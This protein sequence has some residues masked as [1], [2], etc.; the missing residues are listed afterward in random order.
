ML[1]KVHGSNTRLFR[2]SFSEPQ[3]TVRPPYEI[4]TPSSWLDVALDGYTFAEDYQTETKFIEG[5]NYVDIKISSLKNIQRTVIRATTKD[6]SKVVDGKGE[7]LA[8]AEAEAP[9]ESLSN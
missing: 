5:L 6:A 8:N 4:N 2:I 9:F 3:V 1:S 7:S